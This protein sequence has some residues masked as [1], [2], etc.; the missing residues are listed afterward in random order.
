MMFEEMTYENLLDDVLKNAPEDIDTRP[1]S[2]FYDA[3]SGV[4]VKIAK[5]YA[6]LELI[7]TL[8]QIETTA[9]EY[10]D[11]RASEFGIVRREALCAKYHVE[12]EGAEPKSG[13][14]FFQDG[15]YFALEYEENIPYLVAEISGTAANNILPGTAAIPVNS[16]SGLTVSKFGK[17]SSYGAEAEDNDSLR[18][19][20]FEKISSTG[21]NGNKQHYKIWCESIKGVGKARIFPL[22]NGANTV[23]AVLIGYDGQPCTADVTVEVQEY[24]DPGRTGLGEGMANLGAHFTAVS[25]FEIPID[26]S[27]SV[28]HS[29]GTV[30]S[31]E[32][33]L[34]YVR[35]QIGEI[36]A[37]YFKDVVLNSKDNKITVSYSK[38]LALIV[39]N[40][41]LKDY[42]FSKL[43]I[44]I[45]G[46]EFIEGD[47][48]IDAESV[49]VRGS[50]RINEIL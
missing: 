18:R 42:N 40:E 46:G 11:S 30:L 34:E 13:E 5:L 50:V 17:I 33:S 47:I 8:T 44:T 43:R 39:I 3:V 10:L 27:I 26:I 16:I 29:D 1:G 15:I 9:D 31:D 19:R 2:I 6:D 45:D 22:W 28:K 25:A 37:D 20:L 7:H 38:I 21:E 4:L 23:K 41:N 36:A 49:P 12:F 24:I 14:R 32:A 48:G 35:N